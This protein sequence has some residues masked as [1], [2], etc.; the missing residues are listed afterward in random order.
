MNSIE[1]AWYPVAQAADLAAR[2]VFHGELLGHELAL[3]RADSGQVNAWD[4]RCPHRS[5]R[6][7]LGSNNGQQLRCQYHGWQY[8]SGDGQCV[9][10]PS[11]SQS[12]PPAKLCA[13]TFAAVERHGYVWVNLAESDGMASPSL[14]IGFAVPALPLRSMVIKA[15]L[16]TVAAALSRYAD[17]AAPGAAQLLERSGL[18][19]EMRLTGERLLFWLQPANDAKTIVHALVDSPTAPIIATLRRHNAALTQ[20]RNALEQNQLAPPA[21]SPKVFPLRDITGQSPYLRAVVERRWDSAAD[22]MALKLRLPEGYPLAFQAGAHIDVKTP[23]GVVRQYSL[24]NA[25]GERDGLTIGVKLEPAS[26]GGSRSLHE[27]VA[28]GDLLEISAPKNHFRLLPGQGGLLIAGGIGITPILAMGQQ[29]E[30]Q[31][32]PYALHYFTRSRAHAAF[33][34]RLE[35]L[36]GLRL[37]TGLSVDET[38][39]AI[40][41]ALQLASLDTQVYVCGPQALLELVRELA[42]ARDLAEAQV[43][44]EL[45]ANEVSHADERPFKVRLQQS[46]VELPVPAGRSLAEVLKEHGVALDTS[47]EQGVCGTCRVGLI[48]GEPEHRDVYLTEQEKNSRTC[49]MPCVSRSRS[50]LLVL[51]L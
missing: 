6:L 39:A 11:S 36:A 33:A 40:T 10:I 49:L 37:H 7:T 46:G 31:H 14:P 15:E 13:R 21:A 16:E 44:F 38:R 48:D 23:A 30:Q 8:Q 35:A 50:E 43:H 5:V 18:A 9:A 47:C 51:D 32:L 22:I 26:R 1:N 45:F 29:L 2:H 42:Q 28:Q 25:P 19:I 24:V 4:N 3:W 27:Q 12:T 41:E 34:E 20:L 17:Y